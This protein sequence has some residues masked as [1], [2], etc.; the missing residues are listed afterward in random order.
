MIWPCCIRCP[1][2]WYCIYVICITV[3]LTIFMA[4]TNPYFFPIHRLS[5]S[6]QILTSTYEYN[7]ICFKNAN[8]WHNHIAFVKIQRRSRTIV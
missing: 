3:R 2:T 4:L 5:L 8:S 7:I 1:Y 6:V